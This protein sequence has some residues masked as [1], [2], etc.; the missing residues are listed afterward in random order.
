VT[1]TS[2]SGRRILERGSYSWPS[3]F[4]HFR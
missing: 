3:N 1:Y 4:I 2:M